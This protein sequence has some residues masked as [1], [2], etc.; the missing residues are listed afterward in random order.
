MQNE[1][2]KQILKVLKDIDSK[3]SI[4]I[5]LQKTSFT[6]PKLGAEEK[7]ILKLCNGKNTIKEIMEITSKK[8]NNVKSTLS[9]LRKKG[10]IK[11]TTMNKKIVYVKI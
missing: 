9:H 2:D 10:I 7:A 4:L 1:Q 8:K 6:P 11:S 3:L 5:S